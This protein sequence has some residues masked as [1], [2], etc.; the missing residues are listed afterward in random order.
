MKSTGYIWIVAD[1]AWSVH[2]VWGSIGYVWSMTDYVWGVID[3]VWGLQR[4]DYGWR[5]VVRTVGLLLFEGK[6]MCIPWGTVR[7]FT[8][9]IMHYQV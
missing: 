9:F 2:F 1:S 5:R 6:S 3:Y 8:V 7:S 4:T